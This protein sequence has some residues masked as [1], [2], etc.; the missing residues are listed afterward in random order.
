MSKFKCNSNNPDAAAPPNL[1]MLSA[2]LTSLQIYYTITGTLKFTHEIVFAIII[3]LAGKT[4]KF[5]P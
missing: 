3:W 1:P 5:T 2:C 4:K